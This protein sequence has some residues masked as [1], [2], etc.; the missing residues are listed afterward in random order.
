MKPNGRVPI[1]SRHPPDTDS[2]LGDEPL[3]TYFEH[4]LSQLAVLGT[5]TNEVLWNGLRHLVMIGY[6]PEE[7]KAEFMRF[8]RRIYTEKPEEPL[9]DN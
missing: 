1:P 8:C 9:I 6:T 5:A 4:L 3:Q 2:I 7:V